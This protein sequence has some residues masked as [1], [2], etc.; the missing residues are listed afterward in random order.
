VLT[1]E[2]GVAGDAEVL[3][4]RHGDEDRVDVLAVQQLAIVGIRRH[5]A[6]GGLEALLEVDVPVVAD[7]HAAPGLD[8]PE[9][10]LFGQL[11]AQQVGAAATGSNESVGHRAARGVDRP[12]VGRTL[13][14]CGD[15]GYGRSGLENVAA[16]EVARLRHV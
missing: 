7:G 2:Q 6:S 10:L 4:Q 14:G 5:R 13:H 16:G 12:N 8:G 15:G 9:V 3:V 1:G 11:A